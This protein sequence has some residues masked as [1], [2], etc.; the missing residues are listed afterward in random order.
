MT[1]FDHPDLRLTSE[2]W[3]AADV[4]AGLPDGDVEELLKDQGWETFLS[5]GDPKGGMRLESWRRRRD[6][7][8]VEYLLQVN[9]G[10]E[11]SPFL[12]VESFPELMDLFARWAPAVQAAAVAGMIEELGESELSTH[13]G[14][15]ETIAARAAHGVAQTLPILER[16]KRKAD[17][18]ARVR[19]AQ[20]A[21]ERAAQTPPPGPQSSP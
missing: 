11:Y 17:E 12:V 13:H 4:L 20:R 18:R 10:L 16:E 14:L 21:A 5:M 1:T 9:G 19:A 8:P 7:Q 2:G 6:G 15:V 3:V